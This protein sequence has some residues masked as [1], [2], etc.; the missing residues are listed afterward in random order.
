QLAVDDG[1]EPGRADPPV[2]EVAAVAVVLDL[3]H[4]LGERTTP[5]AEGEREVVGGQFGMGSNDCGLVLEAGRSQAQAHVDSFTGP[6]SECFVGPEC[7]APGNPGRDTRMPANT[8]MGQAGRV[9]VSCSAPA[10]KTAIRHVSVP[11][12][13]QAWRVPFWTTVSP[14]LRWTST[15]S[16]SSSHTSPSRTTSKS[17]VSV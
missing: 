11:L 5:E 1:G 12:L 13:R 6:P 8:R 14:G 16:S 15:P 2:R 7:F 4:E 3:A 9:T 17:I 10:M